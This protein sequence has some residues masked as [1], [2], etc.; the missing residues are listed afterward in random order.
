MSFLRTF[1]DEINKYDEISQID[2]DYF[3]KTWDLFQKYQQLSE[4]I[5]KQSQLAQKEKTHLNFELKK[6]ASYFLVSAYDK[7]PTRHSSQQRE[8][9]SNEMNRIE[10]LVN[11]YRLKNEANKLKTTTD[12]RVK[13]GEF[14]VLIEKN[15]IETINQYKG[16]VKTRVEDYFS[17][18]QS[19]NFEIKQNE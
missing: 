6:F 13:I 18:F 5:Y 1:N 12:Q 4:N 14:L 9:I 15:L 19:I 2:A 10:A 11:F 17:Q 3:T 16:E 8:E 7:L